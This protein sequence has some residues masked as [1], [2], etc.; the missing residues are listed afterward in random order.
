M[1]YRSISSSLSLMSGV[2][3]SPIVAENF[4]PH[5]G[6]PASQDQTLVLAG[7]AFSPSSDDPER[8]SSP[9]HGHFLC[10]LQK[11]SLFYGC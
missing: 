3:F 8:S 9:G 11:N 4:K 1:V 5:L 2:N 6:P 7:L 10:L